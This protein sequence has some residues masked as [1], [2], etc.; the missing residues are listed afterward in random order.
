MLRFVL[1]ILTILA[2][3]APAIIATARRGNPNYSVYITSQFHVIDSDDDHPRKPAYNFVDTSFWR[4]KIQNKDKWNRLTFTDIDNGYA[5]IVAGADSFTMN[6]M[7]VNKRLPPN[8]TNGSVGVNGIICLDT[9]GAGTN[10]TEFPVNPVKGAVAALWT[11]M[12]LRTTGDSSKVFYRVST[13]SFYVT[14]YNL[15]LKGTNGK[16]RVTLQVSFSAAD[17]TVQINYRNFEGDMCGEP[18]AK[19]FQRLASIGCQSPNGQTWTNYLDRGLY[20]ARSYSSSIY[21]QDLHD[22]LAIKYIRVPN[23]M[24]RVRSFANPASD[25]YETSVAQFTPQVKID[26]LYTDSLRVKVRNR[27][28]NLATG[29]VIYDRIDSGTI[30]PYQFTTLQTSA[31]GLGCGAYRLNTTVTL[32]G[33]ATWI[34][35]VTATDPW[36]E[37]NTLTHD[38]YKFTSTPAFP[39]FDDY[40]ALDRCE[41]VFKGLQKDTAHLLFY[42]PPNP[43]TSGALIFDRK[44]ETGGRYPRANQGDTLISLPFNLAGKSN[45]WLEFSYQRGRRTDS[46]QAAIYLRTLSGPDPIITTGS[47]GVL[48]GDSLIIEAIPSSAATLNPSATAWQTIGKIYGGLDYETK[49]FRLQIPSTYIH[50]H[51]RF[52]IRYAPTDHTPRLCYAYDD[53]DAFIVDELQLNAPEFGRKNETDTEPLSIDLGNG[54]FTHLPRNVKWLTP[55]VRLASNGLQVNSTFYVL[56][57]VLWDALNREV[58]NR[59]QTFLAPPA[60]KDTIISMPVWNIEGS[61]GGRFKAMVYVQLSP[62]EYRRTNDTAIFYRTMYIDD[63]YGL[64]DGQHDTAGKMVAADG[65]FTYLFRPLAQDSLRGFD[66]YHPTGTGISNWTVTIKGPH[67]SDPLLAVRSFSYNA[68][69][70]GWWRNTFTP[71][72]MTPDSLYKI[73][74]QLTQGASTGGD[75]SRGLVWVK[76]MN[77]TA[78][79]YDALYPSVVGSFK[80]QSGAL[81]FSSSVAKND[82]S[83]GPL[84]PMM[85]LVFGGSST[86]LPVELLSFSATRRTGGDVRLNFRTAQEQNLSSFEIERQQG[87]NWI[88][89]GTIAGRNAANGSVY[90]LLD[91]DAPQ[92]RTRY[93]LWEIDLDGSRTMLGTAE[94]GPV[95]EDRTLAVRSV[96][97]P[98]R[99]QFTLHLDGASFDGTTAVTI[100]DALGKAV[101]NFADIRSNAIDVDARSLPAGTYY[102][103]LRDGGARARTMIVVT[104]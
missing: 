99:D 27:I 103:E 53:D 62:N 68:G 48:Q 17:S 41:Y 65:N 82:T 96:P 25:R 7:G 46:S 2:F 74:F 57:V 49:K 22:Q 89:A 34:G 39:N 16:V 92:S 9:A 21:A 86:F 67:S 80:E 59:T 104:L 95:G 3:L 87:D 81:Y 76:G 56:H 51:T 44:D 64:D 52:R 13:D 83:F 38:F 93:R 6:F 50:G 23:N 72:Y 31:I 101:R 26:N 47:G 91:A 79:M 1:R 70:P 28:T 5:T 88:M 15:A 40:S 97:N 33:V 71:F 20:F 18:A 75:A 54:F 32:L 4:D 45:V 73:Q 37:D 42:D 11:D 14:Y 8:A 30:N 90:E 24:V 35:T 63:M 102:I 29:S 36:T 100:Y 77:G 61:Q 55:K 19:I 10:N 98:A 84:L 78:K 94:A 12:E 69:T 58:Y 43:A 85:R 66:L 60:R